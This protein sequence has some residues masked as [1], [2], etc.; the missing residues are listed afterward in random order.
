MSALNDRTGPSADPLAR[1]TYS[2]PFKRW[3]W[4]SSGWDFD[5]MLGD[6]LYCGEPVLKIDLHT[7][8]NLYYCSNFLFIWIAKLEMDWLTK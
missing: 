3:S 2:I 8:Y 7:H 5:A 1:I 4:R 6:F